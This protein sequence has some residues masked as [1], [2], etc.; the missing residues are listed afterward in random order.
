MVGNKL[1]MIE[2]QDGKKFFLKISEQKEIKKFV[3]TMN[4]KMQIVKSKEI[5]GLSKDEFAVAFCDQSYKTPD[6]SFVI[7]NPVKN[8]ST[9]SV[10]GKR[11]K[12]NPNSFQQ[13]F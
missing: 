7:M 1:I 11:K 2:K 8:I 12:S 3:E 10:R 5:K 9:L 6:S 13:E 4:L